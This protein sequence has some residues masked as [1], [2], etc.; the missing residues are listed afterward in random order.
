M[1]NSLDCEIKE[2]YMIKY[3]FPIHADLPQST[4]VTTVS[5]TT[6][7]DVTLTTAS[8]HQRNDNFIGK[9][10]YQVLFTVIVIVS[11]IIKLSNSDCLLA[12]SYTPGLFISGF[13]FFFLFLCFFFEISAFT[14]CTV[15]TIKP[16]NF[17]MCTVAVGRTHS[18]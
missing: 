1:S 4:I 5:T 3:P 12:V 9:S 6:S 8:Q 15:D 11:S 17:T 14:L 18:T 2:R 13:L 7:V 16:L 10:Q